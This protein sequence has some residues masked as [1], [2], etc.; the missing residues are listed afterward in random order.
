MRRAD[1]NV[2]PISYSM[3]LLIAQYEAPVHQ[4]YGLTTYE[5]G[6]KY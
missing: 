6:N 5:I 2:H 1:E 4:K 3:T